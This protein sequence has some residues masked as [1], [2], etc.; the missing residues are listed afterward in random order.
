[1]AKGVVALLGPDMPHLQFP[2][3]RVV[4][5]GHAWSI[6]LRKRCAVHLLWRIQQGVYCQL[7]CSGCW[8]RSLQLSLALPLSNCGLLYDG[9]YGMRIDYRV[10]C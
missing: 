6:H 3:R 8:P 4:N 2:Y 10:L 5:G 1:M 7:R 9:Y